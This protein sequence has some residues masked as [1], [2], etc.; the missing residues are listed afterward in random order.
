MSDQTSVIEQINK[1]LET[2]TA[3]LPEV[4][5]FAYLETKLK[6]FRDCAKKYV[7]ILPRG[8]HIGARYRDQVLMQGM[9][10]MGYLHDLNSNYVDTATG[11]KIRAAIEA[12]VMQAE[13][14]II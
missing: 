4:K 11:M 2:I 5:N 10:L 8:A 1:E 3:L 12:I 6:D 9:F 14:N 7:A 13:N